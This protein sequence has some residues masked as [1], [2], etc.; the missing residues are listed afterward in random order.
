MAE[1][2]FWPQVNRLIKTKGINLETLAIACQVP[3]STLNGWIKN[4]YFPSIVEGYKIARELGVSVE[5]LITG[6]K[7]P[8]KENLETVRSLLRKAEEILKKM[9]G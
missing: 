3:L 5:Y 2:N 6:Q 9:Q 1:K 7:N 4:D 8:S